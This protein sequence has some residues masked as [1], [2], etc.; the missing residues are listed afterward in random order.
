MNTIHKTTLNNKDADGNSKLTPLSNRDIEE[1]FDILP[2][3][4]ELLHQM[5]EAG[6]NAA[7]NNSM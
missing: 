7:E 4:G 5:L 1:T 6:S 3:I 2:L